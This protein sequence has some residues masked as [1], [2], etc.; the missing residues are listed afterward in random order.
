MED[1]RDPYRVLG[2]R[3]DAGDE[4]IKAAFR[5]LGEEAFGGGPRAERAQL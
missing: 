4:E 3:E 5:A 1:G 2:V